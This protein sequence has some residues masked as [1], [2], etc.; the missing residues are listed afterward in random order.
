MTERKPVAIRKLPDDY[1]GAHL[2][3]P[4]VAFYSARAD[5]MYA[6]PWGAVILCSYVRSGES[7]V[8]IF[9]LSTQE[10]LANIRVRAHASSRTHVEEVADI[11]TGLYWSFWRQL[12]SRL[13]FEK[14]DVYAVTEKKLDE[15]ERDFEAMWKKP[16][17][18]C[19][20]IE[21]NDPKSVYKPLY[22]RELDDI[23]AERNE[24]RHAI[25]MACIALADAFVPE[26][27][28]S[29][30]HLQGLS[31][32]V[33]HAV[34]HHRWHHDA[35]DVAYVRKL[36][37]VR[38]ELQAEVERQK[39]A[40]LKINEVRNSIVGRQTVSF[41]Q[42]VYP[43]VAA[44]DEAG[45]KGADYAT[46]RKQAEDEIERLTKKLDEARAGEHRAHVALGD[47]FGSVVGIEALLAP[48]TEDEEQLAGG[49]YAQEAGIAEAD[50]AAAGAAVNA[51][52]DA[53]LAAAPKA[54]SS[55]CGHVDL[56]GPVTEEDVDVSFRAHYANWYEAPGQ[57]DR[58]MALAATRRALEA[59]VKHRRSLARGKP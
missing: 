46:C 9:D 37:Q 53:R 59:F 3:P 18:N 50:W 28:R 47:Q 7:D 27:Q 54:T 6:I 24:A 56:L 4:E 48:V 26:E 5:R 14:S 36:E 57:G 42:H 58:Y 55:S 22:E 20:F 12:T 34:E 13:G 16:F 40:L 21:L 29:G 35:T 32:L 8:R 44:L 17:W 38:D 10:P 11:A 43:L 23:K 52:L 1:A 41:S 15:A 39:Q 30:A 19:R 31:R 49:A 45:I 2:K 51:V 33:A 25:K